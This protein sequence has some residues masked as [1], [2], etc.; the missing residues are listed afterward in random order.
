M[1]RSKDDD[2]TAPADKLRRVL[3]LR[4]VVFDM[5]QDIDVQDAIETRIIGKCAK[6]SDNYMGCR[7]CQQRD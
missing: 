5:F 7:S 1:G 2:M 6:G 4:A 3:D